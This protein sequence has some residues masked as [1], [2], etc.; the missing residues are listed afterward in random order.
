MLLSV[1]ACAIDTIYEDNKHPIFRVGGS[2]CNVSYILANLGYPVT[3]ITKIGM[4]REGKYIEQML[5]NIGVDTKYIFSDKSHL[6]GKIR[7]VVKYGNHEYIF[8]CKHG[9]KLPEMLMPTIGEITDEMSSLRPKMFYFQYVNDATI[10]FAKKFRDLKIPVFF[11]PQKINDTS[12]H[13]EILQYCNVVKYNIEP[14]FIPE[15]PLLIHTMGRN[16]TE[17]NLNYNGIKH[18]PAFKIPIVVDAGGAGDHMTAGLLYKLLN[19]YSIQDSILYGHALAS[20]SCR[21]VGAHGI[22]DVIDKTNIINLADRLIA[23]ENIID[24]DVY[25]GINKVYKNI[26]FDACMCH[27]LHE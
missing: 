23:K 4:D 16:G 14:E 7:Q 3:N 1:G 12:E 24:D 20:L 11:E 13:R 17:Y 8:A 10:M 6:T 21:F 2:L 22:E 25:A 19:G 15:V 18:V 26:V 9:N 5:S 27:K